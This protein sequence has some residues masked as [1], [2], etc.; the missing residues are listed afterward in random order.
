MT[1]SLAT[2]NRGLKTAWVASLDRS[3]VSGE[4]G[5]STH[6]TLKCWLIAVTMCRSVPR[7]PSHCTPANQTRSLRKAFITSGRLGKQAISAA[8]GLWTAPR[9]SCHRIARNR[10]GVLDMLS[11]GSHP[12][13]PS[14]FSPARPLISLVG[15]DLAIFLLTGSVFV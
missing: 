7:I 11:P 3:E 5:G 10:T 9:R 15:C 4:T 6:S 13:D 12:A 14:Y 2:D 8:S 1:R